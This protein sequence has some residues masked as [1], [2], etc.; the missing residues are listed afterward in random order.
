MALAVASPQNHAPSACWKMR[1]T[2]RSPSKTLKSVSDQEPDGREALA[3]RRIRWV[4]TRD[5][6]LHQCGTS[7]QDLPSSDRRNCPIANCLADERVNECS[8]DR[9]RDYVV[10]GNKG[11][12]SRVRFNQ[13]DLVV[14]PEPVTEGY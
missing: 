13:M 10:V 11:G 8:F 6:S 12:N 2:S 14:G 9:I 7:D 1:P 5:H 4:I 3:R